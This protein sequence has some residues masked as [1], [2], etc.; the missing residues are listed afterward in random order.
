MA[1]RDRFE[2]DK[3]MGRRSRGTED[4]EYGWSS[5]VRNGA[6]FDHGS[7]I[8]TTTTDTKL[9]FSTFRASQGPVK[10]M[11]CVIIYACRV[12]KAN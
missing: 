9:S 10:T 11:Q 7:I 1:A 6:H 2:F 3:T 5:G 4:P 8:C 12:S